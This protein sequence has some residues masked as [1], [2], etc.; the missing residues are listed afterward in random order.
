M[1]KKVLICLAVCFSLASAETFCDG[2]ARGY[3]EA[4]MQF[5]TGKNL[6]SLTIPGCPDPYLN[7]D[8][9]LDGYALGYTVAKMQILNN[10]IK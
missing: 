5:Y 6:A 4:V 2:W 10:K 1:L 8:T 7:Q 3:V 9:F